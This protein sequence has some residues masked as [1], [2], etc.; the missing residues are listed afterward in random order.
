MREVARLSSTP[1]YPV[2]AQEFLSERGISLVVERPLKNTYLDGAVLL[3]DDGRPVIGLT[4][5]YDRIDNFWFTLVH[6]LA[7]VSLNLDGDEGRAFVDDLDLRGLSPVE[8]EADE[9]AEETLIPPALWEASGAGHQPTPIAVYEHSLR[10]GV[11]MAVA[12]GRVRLESGNYRLLSQFVGNGEV[13]RL[14]G[15]EVAE[16]SDLHIWKQK[17]GR[18]L[19]LSSTA[20]D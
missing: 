7:H 9:L 8:D 12:V 5:R 11:H 20:Q 16:W 3:G 10:A 14:L 19:H 17:V 2:Y 15:G 6:E 4:L 1:D 18:E 13:R